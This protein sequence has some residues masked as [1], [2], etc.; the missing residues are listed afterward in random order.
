M[1]KIYFTITGT[2]YFYGK[3]FLEPGMKV[4]L[5]KEKDNEYDDEAILVKLEGLGAIGHVANSPI[6]VKGESYSAGR[7]FDKIGDTSYGTIMYVLDDGVLCSLDD[8]CINNEC[9]KKHLSVKVRLN[10]SASTS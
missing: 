3:Q 4:T 2:K 8:V 5:E 1:K 9:R 6:T 7:I 10:K